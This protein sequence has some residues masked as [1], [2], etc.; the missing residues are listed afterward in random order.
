MSIRAFK[1][2]DPMHENGV[3]V[4]AESYNKAKSMVAGEMCVGGYEYHELQCQREPKA[5]KFATQEASVVWWGGK[6]S[7]EIYYC[8]GW[9]YHDEPSCDWCG[10]GQFETIPE[11]TVNER[12]S[13]GEERVCNSCYDSEMA[14][15]REA[16]Q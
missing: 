5:D 14:K 15:K 3:I 10:Q 2:H 4:F 6:R 8:L 13:I 1:V 9:H 11:S 7:D 12:P 16:K